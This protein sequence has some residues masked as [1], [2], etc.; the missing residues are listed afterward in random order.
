MRTTR[1]R[2]FGRARQKTVV[3]AAMRSAR[4]APT[5]RVTPRSLVALG[6]AALG[7]ALAAAPTSATGPAYPG[8]GLSLAFSLPVKV[9]IARPG[10]VLLCAYSTWVTDTAAGAQLTY[11]VRRNCHTVTRRLHG[12]RREVKVCAR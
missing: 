2:R 9:T 12:K 11:T 6:A 3:V 7:A 10:P 8:E 1:R 4:G 5:I